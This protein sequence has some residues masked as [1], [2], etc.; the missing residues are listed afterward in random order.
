MGAVTSAYIK[1]APTVRPWTEEGFETV[2]RNILQWACNDYKLEDGLRDLVILIPQKNHDPDHALSDVVVLNVPEEGTGLATLLKYSE[3]MADKLQAVGAIVFTLAVKM[4][5][6]PVTLEDAAKGD[7]CL[8]T[9]CQHQDF[10]TQRVYTANMKTGR[11]T[12]WRRV[13]SQVEISEGFP[14]FLRWQATN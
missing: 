2:R 9:V 7:L 5:T 1:L 12:P 13:Q 3:E 11:L 8:V 14:N 10:N 6:I 4:G